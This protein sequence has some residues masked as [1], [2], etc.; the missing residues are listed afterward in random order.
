MQGLWASDAL[1]LGGIPWCRVCLEHTPWLQQHHPEC[2]ACKGSRYQ[3]AAE[4]TSE[5]PVGSH[6]EQ[7]LLAV[8]STRA[9]LQTFLKTA[10]RERH[11]DPFAERLL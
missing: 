6:L 11:V 8:I 7:V 10:L 5:P 3:E 9:W 2:P 4:G 1:W